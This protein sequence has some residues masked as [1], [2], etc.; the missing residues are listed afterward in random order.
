MHPK[1]KF[2]SLVH[3]AI[4]RAALCWLNKKK[5][6]NNEK[7][8]RSKVCN[9]KHES[10]AIQDYFLPN[11]L[12]NKQKKLLFS[13]KSR[14]VDVHEN[15]K[16]RYKNDTTCRLCLTQSE[17]QQHILTCSEILKDINIVSYN[18]LEYDDIFSPDVSKQISVT[19]LFESLYN[20]RCVLL[21]RKE[22]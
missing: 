12:N 4:L 21:K 16:Q 17:S 11:E 18:Q 7:D 14:M 1:E 13:L 22:T 20:H 19:R 3:K 5:I 2:R 10:L 8:K 9:V 6:G 15:Y